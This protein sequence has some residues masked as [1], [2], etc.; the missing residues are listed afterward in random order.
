M[1][2]VAV[3]FFSTKTSVRPLRA[4]SACTTSCSLSRLSGGASHTR[5]VMPPTVL[6]T[7]PTAIQTY[8]RRK[9]AA[10]FW[11]ARG[12]VAE[13]SSVCRAWSGVGVGV[14]IGSGLVVSG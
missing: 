4:A 1:S 3:R 10:R 5:C 9:A 14:G 6:P 12:N 7:R 8:G 2:Q 13:K 11:M